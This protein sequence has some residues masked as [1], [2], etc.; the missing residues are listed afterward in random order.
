M[1]LFRWDYWTIRLGIIAAVLLFFSG[2]VF[3]QEPRDYFIWLGLSYLL[4]VWIHP[5][6]K[7]YFFRRTVIFDY[8]GVVNVGTDEDYYIGNIFVR[9]GMRELIER[10]KVSN[11]VSIFTNNPWEAHMAFSRKLGLD[12]LFDF[13]FSSGL[14]H[15]R[16]P[17]AEAYRLVLAGLSSSPHNSVMIDDRPENLT[18]AKEIGMHT[19]V[20]KNMEQLQA[21]LRALGYKF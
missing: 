13:Q 10:L 6:F 4:A 7:K 11:K 3:L 9:P 18:G 12:T 15:S 1:G 17:N 16:K 2:W 21:D 14:V 20:F 19:I 5:Y 8:V